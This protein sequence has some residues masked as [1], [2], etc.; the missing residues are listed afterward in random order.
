MTAIRVV[1]VNDKV[2][3]DLNCLFLFFNCFG[4]TGK[5]K[6]RTGQIFYVLGNN[7]SEERPVVW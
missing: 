7:R 5:K 2:V 6:P 1:G 3:V 4:S